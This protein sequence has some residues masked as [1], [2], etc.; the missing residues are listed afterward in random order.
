[1]TGTQFKS[2][3]FNSWN[4]LVKETFPK[5]NSTIREIIIP[6]LDKTLTAMLGYNSDWSK[7]KIDITQIFEDNQITGVN[8][9]IIYT[10]DDFKVPTAPKE[11]IQTDC[12]SITSGFDNIEL[13]EVKSINI[14]T[15]SGEL[16]IIFEILFE[17]SNKD[18]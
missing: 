5:I 10:V 18:K 17:D 8:C 3:N 12:D 11:A 14:N 13:F 2:G 6:S 7:D 16:N 4:K 1:M 15:T 9:N